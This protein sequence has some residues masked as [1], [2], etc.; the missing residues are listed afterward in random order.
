MAG[1]G[2]VMGPEALGKA[3]L[4]CAAHPGGP[5]VG[6]LL[7]PRAGEA[8]DA[9]PLVHSLSAAATAPA[10]ETALAQVS[11]PR[12]GGGGGGGGGAVDADGRASRASPFCTYIIS[13]I[14]IARGCAPPPLDPARVCTAPPPNGAPGPPQSPGL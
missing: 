11:S 1:G 14:S 9:A 4:H 5:C 7:G 12:G 2:L 10:L 13:E 6:L 3:L 8:V